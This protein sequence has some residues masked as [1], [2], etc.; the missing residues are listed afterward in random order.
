MKDNKKGNA[1]PLALLCF[2]KKYINVSAD[3][4]VGMPLTALVLL[5]AFQF[6]VAHAESG[7]KPTPELDVAATARQREEMRSPEL[8]KPEV[9]KL[10]PGATWAAFLIPKDETPTATNIRALVRLPS[11]DWPGIYH[12]FE[13]GLPISVPADLPIGVVPHLYNCEATKGEYESKYLV[14][15]C[16]VV[17][18]TEKVPSA[19]KIGGVESRIATR[20]LNLRHRGRMIQ[21]T[22]VDVREP[23]RDSYDVIQALGLDGAIK[24]SRVYLIQTYEINADLGCFSGDYFPIETVSMSEF[25]MLPGDDFFYAV[26]DFQPGQCNMFGGLAMKLAFDTGLPL[27]QNKHIKAVNA[28]EFQA[29]IDEMVLAYFIEYPEN[30]DRMHFLPESRHNIAHYELPPGDTANTLLEFINE[31]TKKRYFQDIQ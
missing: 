12:D 13:T 30:E 15:S 22:D 25:S 18:C 31:Q 3:T 23:A 21:L 16:R 4:S 14:C 24:W 6:S 10:Y 17:G 5:G 7:R 27:T 19:G 29:F 1:M 9:G 28:D 8:K 11:K 2:F 20:Y 26:H